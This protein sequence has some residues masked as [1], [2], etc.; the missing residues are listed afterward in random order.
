[1]KVSNQQVWQARQPLQSLLDQRL[2]VP[3]SYRMLL[4]ARAVNEQI[5]VIDEVRVGLVNRHGAPDGNG[6]IRVSEGSEHWGDWVRDY[7]ELMTQEAELPVARVQLTGA[8][9]NVQ[10]TPNDLLLL[11]PFV[12]VS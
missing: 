2:P 4:L 5:K 8:L 9:E 1:M 12:E 11:E 10:I 6:Q 3:V 7:T